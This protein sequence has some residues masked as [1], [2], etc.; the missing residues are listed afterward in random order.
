MEKG[1]TKV[2]RGFNHSGE[3][4]LLWWRWGLTMVE[5]GSNS[6]GEEA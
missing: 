4:V 6:G 5:R 3:L 2:E 1:L